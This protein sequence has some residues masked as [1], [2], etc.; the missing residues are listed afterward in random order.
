MNIRRY[1][2]QIRYLANNEVERL[3]EDGV[4]TPVSIKMMKDK[5]IL[6]P[7]L[8]SGEDAEELADY[9][10]ESLN[11]DSIQFDPVWSDEYDSYVIEIT[12]SKSITSATEE[13]EDDLE[14]TEQEFTSK[15]TAVNWKAGKLPAIFKLVKFP[16]N[17]L[18]LDYGGGTVESEALATSFLSQ[19]GS[20]D[21]VYDPYNKSAELN[22]EA[23]NRLRKNGGADVAICSNVLNVIAEEAARITVLKNIKKL[24]KKGAPVYITVYE[25]TGQG[26]GKRSGDDQYQ[27]NRKTADY[28]EEVQSVFP[29]AV[30][31]GKL[32][33]ATNSGSSVQSSK[34]ISAGRE[35]YWLDPPE[36]DKNYEDMEEFQIGKEFELDI[37]VVVQEGYWPDPA[38]DADFFAQVKDEECCLI[39]YEGH[40]IKA[41][42]DANSIFEYIIELFE[43]H[44]EGI[45]TEPGRYRMKGEFYFVYDIDGISVQH[46]YINYGE[47]EGIV[48]DADFYT[49]DADVSFNASQ[50]KIESIEFTPID[51]SVTSST[52]I[53]SSD[54]VQYSNDSKKTSGRYDTYQT[55]RY[56]GVMFGIHYTEVNT[57]QD[58]DSNEMFNRFKAQISEIHPYDDGNYA[59]AKIEAGVIKIIRDGRSIDNSYYFTADDMD[60]ENEEWCEIVCNQAIEALRKTNKSVQPRMVHN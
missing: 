33:S 28:L 56:Q 15:G 4:E 30:R 31:K 49:D 57:S 17:A 47:D 12:E 6:I 2:T 21:I 1:A 38:D 24:T 29:D 59:W 25:G 14:T 55:A 35:E 51:S 26:E 13:E 8:V 16:S 19:F 41:A 32:I 40:T 10:H 23:V 39:E 11:I 34:Q 60:V 3:T 52:Q 43:A 44:P 5:M 48:D 54:I 50:S 42:P 18:V 9:L 7:N 58:V 45:P 37:E 53:C 46:N 36:P 20:E 27:N 22:K